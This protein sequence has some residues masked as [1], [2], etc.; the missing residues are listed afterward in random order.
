MSGWKVTKVILPGEINT[1]DKLSRFMDS[2]FTLNTEFKGN[3]IRLRPG[4]IKPLGK[5]FMGGGLDDGLGDINLVKVSTI[6][7]GTQS[8]DRRHGTKDSW[9]MLKCPL[10]YMKDGR[11]CRGLSPDMKETIKKVTDYLYMKGE[12]HCDVTTSGGSFGAG[13]QYNGRTGDPGIHAQVI[14]AENKVTIPEYTKYGMPTHSFGATYDKQPYFSFGKN[15]PVINDMDKTTLG[16]L[17][18]SYNYLC[19]YNNHNNREAYDMG[20]FLKLL[21]Q[22]GF[23]YMVHK[24]YGGGVHIVEELQYCV[25]QIGSP[26]YDALDQLPIKT[27]AGEHIPA[28]LIGREN[29]ET[30]SIDAICEWGV[31]FGMYSAL[32]PGRMFILSRQEPTGIKHYWTAPALV[33]GGFIY[34]PESGIACESFGCVVFPFGTTFEKQKRQGVS[35]SID[36]KSRCIACFDDNCATIGF[37]CR[38]HNHHFLCNKIEC[39]SLKVNFATGSLRTRLLNGVNKMYVCPICRMEHIDFS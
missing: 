32:K 35:R 7:M 4:E 19:Q 28:C 1:H 21:H 5:E 16:Y 39:S 18:D 6:F 34:R 10:K 13:N 22:G 14:P 38:G 23:K 31:H 36:I 26:P 27:G 17:I 25:M 3:A 20:Q 12:Y 24:N 29:F 2:R 9:S 8:H 30:V 33:A 15:A 37:T 11:W